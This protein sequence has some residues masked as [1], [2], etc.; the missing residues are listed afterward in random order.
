MNLKLNV[1]QENSEEAEDAGRKEAGP[2]DGVTEKKEGD[3]LSVV[4]EEPEDISDNGEE[5]PRT[6]SF[7]YY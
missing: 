5:R 2:R 3:V 7:R 4:E 6:V 1:V